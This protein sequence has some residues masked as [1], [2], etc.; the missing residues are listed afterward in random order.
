MPQEEPAVP[1]AVAVVASEVTSVG[2]NEVEAGTYPT[3][4]AT[5]VEDIPTKSTELKRAQSVKEHVDASW[6]FYKHTST[7]FSLVSSLVRLPS[8]LVAYLVPWP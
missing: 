3:E 5:H 8:F 4:P 2:N 1:Y 6:Q 7:S